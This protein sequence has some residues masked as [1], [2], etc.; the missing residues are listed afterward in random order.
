[1]AQH[2]KYR[3]YVLA[4]P[5]DLCDKKQALN[6][7]KDCWQNDS[8]LHVITLNAEM[9]M[10][11]QQDQKLDRIIHQ[12]NLVIPDGAGIVLALKLQGYKTCRLPGIELAYSA[13]QFAAENNISVALIGADPE[14][15]NYLR[16]ALPQQIPKLKLIFWQDGYFDS[17]QQEKILNDINA[18]HAQLVLVAMGVPRQEY[19]I[20]QALQITKHAV[21]I[22]VGGSFDVWAGKTQ[23]A[24][25][26][27]QNCHLEWLYRLIS[28]PWRFKRMSV[29]LPKF[30]WQV[31][32]EF[33]KNVLLNNR[34]NK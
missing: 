26:M 9:I 6:I 12:A 25:R 19:F 1:M 8:S 5:V 3:Q 2:T 7:I 10:S 23:R 33:L 32:V 29:T 18:S 24:P 14:V 4:Y 31:I 17:S 13:L 27:W 20:E 11:A 15:L 34:N 21:F 30:A 28:E 22:G 16:H